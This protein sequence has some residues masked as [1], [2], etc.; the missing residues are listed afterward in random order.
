MILP[1]SLIRT[2]IREK[3]NTENMHIGTCLL[4]DS[5]ADTKFQGGGDKML[6]VHTR[7]FFLYLQRLAP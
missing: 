7:T 6:Q 1:T 5:Y 4:T 2:S 3:R